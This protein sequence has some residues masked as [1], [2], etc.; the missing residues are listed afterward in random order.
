MSVNHETHATAEQTTQRIATFAESFAATHGAKYALGGGESASQEE[1][2][3]KGKEDQGCARPQASL[4]QQV[5]RV[6]ATTCAHAHA[7]LQHTHALLQACVCTRVAASTHARC[8]KHAR[9]L[10]AT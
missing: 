1:K 5:V 10:L 6:H 4:L 7:C 2:E 8:C 9:A 3:Q